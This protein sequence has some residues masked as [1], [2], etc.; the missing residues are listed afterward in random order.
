MIGRFVIPP[1]WTEEPE[2]ATCTLADDIPS[3]RAC[4]TEF[5][6]TPSCSSGVGSFELLIE[7]D[8]PVIPGDIQFAVDTAESWIDGSTHAPMIGCG[9]GFVLTEITHINRLQQEIILN[10]L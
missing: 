2:T 8:E 9:K 7:L 5:C 3:T 6:H 4:D 10:I 1:N